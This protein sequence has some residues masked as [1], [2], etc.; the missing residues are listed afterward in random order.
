MY[1]HDSKI[2]ILSDMSLLQ[3]SFEEGVMK[4]LCYMKSNLFLFML[5]LSGA[6]YFGS[7]ENNTN[8]N[9]LRLTQI[10]YGYNFTPN[11]SALF[12]AFV[13]QL[14]TESELV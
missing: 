1:G 2:S 14:Q 12:L 13:E 9:Y 4:Y 8:H 3:E 10:A 11:E 6:L 7:L 5:L